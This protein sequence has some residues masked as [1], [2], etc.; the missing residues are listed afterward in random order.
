MFPPM[1]NAQMNDELKSL[2]DADKQ[3]RIDQP[4]VN[5]AEYKAMRARDLAT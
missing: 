3:E 2:Y 5:T 4:K 1:I